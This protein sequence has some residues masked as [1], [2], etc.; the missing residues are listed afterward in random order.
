MSRVKTPQRCQTDSLAADTW[1][2]QN[3]T[4]F[5]FLSEA[6]YRRA[7]C[8]SVPCEGVGER[9]ACVQIGEQV[10]FEGLEG[11]PDPVMNTKEGKY[12]FAAVQPVSATG[13]ETEI[14][15][16]FCRTGLTLYY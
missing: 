12:P 5:L 14:L 6:W 15:S 13:T 1:V 9:T 10:T 8:N 16:A 4:C 3:H 2:K 7:A 11:E